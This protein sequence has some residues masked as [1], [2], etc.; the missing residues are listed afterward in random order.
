MNDQTIILQLQLGAME[1]FTYIIGDPSTGEGTVIDPWNDTDAILSAAAKNKLT[2]KSVLLTHG[3][4]DHTG[5]VK[6]FSE[7]MNLPVYLSKD[8]FMLYVPACKTLKRLKD[9]DTVAVGTLKIKAISTPGHT[10]GC[11]SY[12]VQENLFTGDTLFIDAVGRADLPGGNSGILF[13]SL[14]RIKNLPDTTMIWPGHH[15]GTRTS[16][17]LSILKTSNPY[18]MSNDANDF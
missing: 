15:Y 16:A 13:Q 2:L 14:Q 4:Y 17:P 7:K 3:H 6:F 1:N 18:L 12:L 9:D 8:E 11:I 5:G 10:P